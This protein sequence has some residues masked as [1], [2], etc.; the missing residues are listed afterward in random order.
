[1]SVWQCRSCKFTSDDPWEGLCPSCRGFYRSVKI[2]VESS[3]QK[4][5][6]TFARANESDTEYTQSGLHEFDRAIGGGLVAG[7]PILLAGFPGT[8]KST[9]AVRVLEKLSSKRK[10]IYAS[11]EED[12]AGVFKIARRAGASSDDVLILGDQKDI[13]ATL[14]RVKQER[15]FLTIF[16]SLQEFDGSEVEVANAIKVD[17]RTRRACAI[18]INQMAKDGSVKGDSKIPH[19]VDTILVLA[20]PKDDP[21]MPEGEDVVRLIVEKN[22][23]GPTTSMKSYWRMNEMGCL[24]PVEDDSEPVVSVR[25]KYRR[26]ETKEAAEP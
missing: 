25:G 24:E 23:N 3:I 15:A 5:R 22:R 26:R 20:L 11:S 18:I 12:D 14:A 6:S 19:A 9:L 13:Y 16:D 2:G 8:G 17:C 4:A 10:C 1:M 21:D 7:S